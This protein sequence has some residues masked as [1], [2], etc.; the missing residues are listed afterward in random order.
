MNVICPKCLKDETVTVDVNDGDTLH[1]NGCDEEFTVG[2]V[3]GLVDSWAK[4]L[5]W[6][7]AHPARTTEPAAA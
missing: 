6:L 7:E 5:P 1:C 4:V 2:D 3:R